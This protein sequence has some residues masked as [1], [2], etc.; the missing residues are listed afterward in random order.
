MYY[1]LSNADLGFAQSRLN[2]V[3]GWQG[4]IDFLEQLE[5]QTNHRFRFFTPWRTG[6]R[7]LDSNLRPDN[8]FQRDPAA[9]RLQVIDDIPL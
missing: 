8:T 4:L 6:M 7:V 3:A 5:D 2:P 1:V 9:R